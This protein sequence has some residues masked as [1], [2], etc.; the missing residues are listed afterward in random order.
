MDI[1]NLDVKCNSC[2]DIVQLEKPA[3]R[4]KYGVLVG[5]L[6]ALFFGFGVGGI[7]G[8]ATAGVGIPAIAPLGLIGG[9]IGFKL[10]K[11]IAGK[12][13]GITCPECDYKYS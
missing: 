7:I 11:W 9:Y 13:D 6:F 12:Q 5:T 1:A 3:N 4:M 8:I 2:S 10:G